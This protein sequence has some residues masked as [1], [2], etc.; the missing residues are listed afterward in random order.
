MHHSLQNNK[1]LA[2]K[3]HDEIE[4]HCLHNG[5]QSAFDEDVVVHPLGLI[6]K[7]FATLKCVIQ[8]ITEAVVDTNI[9]RIW[10]LFREKLQMIL[11]KT[12]SCRSEVT[13]I[14][15]IR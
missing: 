9:F 6:R 2:I 8:A 11:D 13:I 1:E 12:R 14:D 5:V 10:T 4:E 15:Q 3:L 7:A